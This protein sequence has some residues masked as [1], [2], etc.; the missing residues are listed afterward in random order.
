M[1]L[2]VAALVDCVEREVSGLTGVQGEHEGLLKPSIHERPSSRFRGGRLPLSTSST[3]SRSGTAGFVQRTVTGMALRR[4]ARPDPE[5]GR[6]RRSGG[7]PG[8]ARADRRHG[9]RRGNRP[10]CRGGGDGSRADDDGETR[11]D[12]CRRVVGGLDGIAVRA[13]SDGI[14][15]IAG[16]RIRERRD[17][18]GSGG[19]SRTARRH[20]VPT[21]A[22][23]CRRLPC[24][25]PF[26]LL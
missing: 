11:T 12:S 4:V 18:A 22:T 16:R 17:R 21:A 25:R 24:R 5:L 3:R 20:G 23:P 1:G 7:I 2:N 15:E 10:D 13:V 8:I 9:G 14:A 19:F 26:P 6:G